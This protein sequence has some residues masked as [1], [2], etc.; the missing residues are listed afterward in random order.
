MASLGSQIANFF[1][2]ND[3]DTREGL[4]SLFVS[5]LKGIYYAEKQ[6]VDALGEQA[7]ASTTDEVRNAFLQHQ[8]ETRGQVARLEDVFRSIGVEVDDKTCAAIDGLVDDAQMVVSETESGSLTRDAGLIIAGQKIEHHEIAAYGSAVTLASVL[9]Y[10]D[11]ARMLQQTLDEE[12]NTDRKLTQLAESFINQRAAS[13]DDNSS[14]GSSQYGTQGQYSGS[15]Y[16]G[17]GSSADQ[18]GS[19]N[20]DGTRY[21]DSSSTT[22]YNTGSSSSTSGSS[23]I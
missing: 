11:A 20:P 9:G 5:E 1:S 18:Y 8:E 10:S 2:G 21:G 22:G 23:L 3:N 4:Q 19:V 14:S 13:E 15:Q 17:T 12:K 6:A 16:A 7:D